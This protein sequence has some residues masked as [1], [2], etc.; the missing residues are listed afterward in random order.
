[1]AGGMARACDRASATR[2]ADIAL[3]DRARMDLAAATTAQGKAAIVEAFF[4]DVFAQGGT[5]L[6]SATGD[7]V[8]F[9]AKDAPGS[10]AYGVGGTW[11]NWTPSATPLQQVAG[12]ALYAAEVTLPRTSAHEFKMADGANWYE[13]RRALHVAWDGINRNAPGGFNGVV[14]P[15]LRDAAK[16]RLVAWRSVRATQLDD[17]RDVY[18]YVP[19]AYDQPSCPTLPVLYF[20]DGNEALT[21]DTFVTPADATYA[22]T[23]AAAALLVFVALPSQT[24]RMAQYTFGPNSAGDAYLRFLKDDLLPQ[25]ERAWR[26]C[27]RP[28]DR[29][30]SGAS[31]GG[32]ISTY[33]AF[34]H[35]E[36]FGYVGAQSASFFWENSAMVTRAGADPVVPVRF[37][38]DHGSPNDNRV[39]SLDF[40]ARL[41]S[42]GYQH[43]HVEEPNGRHEWVFWQGRLPGLLRY[44]REGRT[45]CA[46]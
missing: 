15:E 34:Q 26:T 38:V 40:V 21:R 9:V 44:F 33:A 12:S 19:A 2:T 8:A 43:R 28:V 1:M 23:P 35:P 7:R 22:A 5:P 46:P 30:L 32:L 42:K 3:L 39:V 41:S 16:G 18:I 31:L 36:L 10:G 17:Y 29:G 14:Y 37:Y 13:D 20:H 45:G 11:N 27:T 6:T 25:V 24:V 4:N